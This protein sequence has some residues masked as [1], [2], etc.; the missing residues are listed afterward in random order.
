MPS[1]LV[2]CMWEPSVVGVESEALAELA[3]LPGQPNPVPWKKRCLLGLVFLD[4]FHQPQNDSGFKANE[5]L[6]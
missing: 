1:L 3:L 4:P 2:K 6:F 5:R